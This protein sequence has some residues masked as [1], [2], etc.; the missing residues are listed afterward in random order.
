MPDRPK[1]ADLATRE[2]LRAVAEH[3]F[4]AYEYLAA[5]YPAKVV[6]AAMCRDTGAGLLEYGV[7]GVRPWLTPLGV[8]RDSELSAPTWQT[9][10]DLAR[11]RQAA[12]RPADCDQC[13][14][15][16]PVR[17]WPTSFCLGGNAP[18]KP[19]RSHCTCD[20]CF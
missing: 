14:T 7:S 15:G 20:M 1:R 9:A 10:D 5:K 19:I 11:L 6:E 12:P 8:R 13:K 17:H 3:E 2:V 18:G 16:T 4:R